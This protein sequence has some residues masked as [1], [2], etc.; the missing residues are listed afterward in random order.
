MN[1]DR[2]LLS[3]LGVMTIGQ[4]AAQMLN[5]AALVF[6]A[7]Q[8]GDHDFGLLQIGVVFSGYAM[9]LAEW[10]LFPLGIRNAARLDDAGALRTYTA[11]HLGLMGLL[12]GAVFILGAI[13]LAVAPLAGVDRMLW[14]L[15]LGMVL[16]QTGMLDWLGI[17]RREM[18]RVSGA[19]VLRSLMYAG[20]VLLIWRHLPAGEA[21]PAY[22]WIPVLLMLSY[23]PGNL[24]MFSASR[25][26]LGG[27]VRPDIRLTPDH[28]SMLK[29]S[30]PICVTHLVR[31]VLYNVDVL[32]LGFLAGPAIAGRYAAAA[33]LL[34]VIVV[35]MEVLL[36]ILLPVLS[37]QWCDDPRR[38]TALLGRYLKYLTGVLLPVVVVCLVFG[39]TL[40]TWIYGDA[41]SGVGRILG[42]LASAYALLSAA[43]LCHEA[44]IAS[45]RQAQGV[46]PLFAGATT[47][48]ILV[49]LA[50]PRWGAI[51]TA[52]SM[53]IAHLVYLL[54]IVRPC[55]QLRTRQ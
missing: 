33:K 25:R 28:R 10:G 14:L 4:V 27:V 47:A 24:V 20:L 38:F 3:N 41:Y 13:L 36:S 55:L 51:G 8:L 29:S 22:R 44:L 18:T 23:I 19:R 34:F 52:F 17:G 37:R 9:V 12:A 2:H 7:R 42:V 32:L 30:A 31:R 11:R 1:D 43:M 21:W 40:T 26:W 48:L 35:G 15:Y 6:L 16:L 39:E 53:L 45:D 54:L 46:V 49:L 50:T 5:L